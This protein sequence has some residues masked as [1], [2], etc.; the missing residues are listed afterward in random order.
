M[1]KLTKVI[2]LIRLFILEADV[3]FHGGLAMPET[4]RIKK[5]LKAIIRQ[6]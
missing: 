6:K 4:W 1:K 5:E 2:A 3:A